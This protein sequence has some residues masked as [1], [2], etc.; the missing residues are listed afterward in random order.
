MQ[1]ILQAKV[2]DCQEFRDAL[3]NSENVI[4]YRVNFFGPLDYINKIRCASRK[5]PGQ[6]RIRWGSCCPF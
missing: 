3:L 6:A 4:Q 1:T 5:L 2:K